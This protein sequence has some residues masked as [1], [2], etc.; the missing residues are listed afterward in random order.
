MLK[1][2]KYQ[3]KLLT[4]TDQQLFNLEQLTQSIEYALVETKVLKGL[5]EGNAV[6]E[7]IRKEMS[8]EEV[9]RLMDET[10][11]AIAYQN[12]ISDIIS[13]Q[14]TPNDEEALERELEGLVEEQTMAQLLSAAPIKPVPRKT[15]EDTV[16]QDE[17]EEAVE[18]TRV[19]VLE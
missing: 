11:E 4:Q 7:N 1:K 8:L 12:Q 9:E 15:V 17:E 14:F 16:S 6:L 18:T 13:G 2:K 10:A 19:P 3:E 5:K